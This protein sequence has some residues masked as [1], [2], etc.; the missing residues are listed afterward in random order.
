VLRRA[1][2]RVHGLIVV[3][4]VVSVTLFVTVADA[5]VSVTNRDDKD[6]KIT[7]VES[8]V[9]RDFVLKPADT[10]RD[11]CPSGCIIRLNDSE[12]DEYILEGIEDVSIEAGNL[13]YDGPDPAKAVPGAATGPS[14]PKAP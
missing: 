12:N 5:A 1:G 14:A 13:Y 11:V 7:V 6:V 4:G 9:G 10:V 2:V 8:G 3:A